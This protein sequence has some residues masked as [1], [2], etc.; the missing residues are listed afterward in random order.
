M[1]I[2]NVIDAGLLGSKSDVV[3]ENKITKFSKE[4]SNTSDPIDNTLNVSKKKALAIS[5]HTSSEITTNGVFITITS[6]KQVRTRT[7]LE[8]P[9]ETSSQNEGMSQNRGESIGAPILSSSIENVSLAS[10]TKGT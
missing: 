2:K 7:P 10:P 9:K 6:Q 1:E 4:V 8:E 3:F 5:S